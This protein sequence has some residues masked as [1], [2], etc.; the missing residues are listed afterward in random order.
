M[1]IKTF[2][3]LI[4]EEEEIYIARCKELLVTAT[5]TTKGEVISNLKKLIE[6]YSKEYKLKE[7]N[8]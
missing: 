6:S 4:Y 3:A 7:L 1:K 5:G 8:F 2:T